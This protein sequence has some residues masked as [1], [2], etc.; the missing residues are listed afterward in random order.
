MEDRIAEEREQEG[1][2]DCC[3]LG[4]RDFRFAGSSHLFAQIKG[5]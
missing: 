3:I 5:D 4:N 1:K 2:I